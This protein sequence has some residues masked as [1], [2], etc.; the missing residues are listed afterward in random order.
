M[1][2]K[3]EEKERQREENK[4][5]KRQIRFGFEGKDINLMK[6]SQRFLTTHQ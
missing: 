6:K 3:E 5:L 1:R 2:V 4:F